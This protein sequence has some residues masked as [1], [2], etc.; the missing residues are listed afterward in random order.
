MPG[1]LLVGRGVEHDDALVVL[2][3]E[4]K[5]AVPARVGVGGTGDVVRLAIRP[6]SRADA[7][8][9]GIGL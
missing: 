5:L 8:R 9:E 1:H 4:L 6:L 2:L 3:G 7:G